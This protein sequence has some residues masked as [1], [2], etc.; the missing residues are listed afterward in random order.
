[1]LC[2]K[3][4]TPSFLQSWSLFMHFLPV[5]DTSIIFLSM[6]TSFD[7]TCNTIYHFQWLDCI[8][9]LLRL[10]P[11]AF[12]FSSVSFCFLPQLEGLATI[13]SP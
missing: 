13:K 9:Q 4:G 11:C 3:H 12:Q 1:M 7:P 2:Y 5:L 6:R 10:Y 8:S